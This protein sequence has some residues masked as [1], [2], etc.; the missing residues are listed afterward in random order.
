[1]E[2]R[3]SRGASRTELAV[4][5]E[6]HDVATPACGVV[7]I[8]RRRFTGRRQRPLVAG[9]PAEEGLREVE[10]PVEVGGGSARFSLSST[11]NSSFQPTRRSYT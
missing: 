11:L 2:R 8:L 1:M 4:V 9:A 7:E 10:D 3:L 5:G 6:H